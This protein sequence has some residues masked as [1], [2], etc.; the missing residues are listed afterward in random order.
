MKVE[1][2]RFDEGLDVCRLLCELFFLESPEEEEEEILEE[3]EDE[4]V[5][6]SP[7]VTLASVSGV[8][9]DAGDDAEVEST[10]I[11]GLT[12]F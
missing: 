2:E 6:S 12:S 11:A 9:A 8:L 5:E 4:T 1:L 10:P 7:S 3:D